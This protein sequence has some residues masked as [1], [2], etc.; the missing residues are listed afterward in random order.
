MENSSCTEYSFTALTVVT[1][2]L[3]DFLFIYIFIFFSCNAFHYNCGKFVI[4]KTSNR[5]CEFYEKY[6]F[7]KRMH[8]Q[9]K[10]KKKGKYMFYIIQFDI[11]LFLFIDCL[12]YRY[13]KSIY[14]SL[15]FS[16]IENKFQIFHFIYFYII[17]NQFFNFS[18]VE[19]IESSTNLK[20]K[21]WKILTNIK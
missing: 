3:L 11:F 19:F 9:E 5:I 10:G 14:L 18:I 16:I 8:G 6:I 7:H 2:V 15:Y 12:F 17:S 13:L 21:S 4:L 1:E 20:F